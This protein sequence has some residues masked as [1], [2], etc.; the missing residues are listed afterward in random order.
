MLYPITWRVPIHLARFL[1]DVRSSFHFD[2]FMLFLVLSAVVV[3]VAACWYF[4]WYSFC[5]FVSLYSMYGSVVNSLFIYFLFLFQW[6]CGIVIVGLHG[7]RIGW[8]VTAN[9][10][11][12]QENV[13]YWLSSRHTANSTAKWHT[14]KNQQRHKL[15]IPHYTHDIQTKCIQMQKKKKINYNYLC[16]CAAWV[17]FSREF[18]SRHFYAMLRNNLWN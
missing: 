14:Q 16:L 9:Q 2:L 1:F 7:N 10:L 5:A 4:N 6:F 12:C 11:L 3:V 17:F 13:V 15:N 18:G 8:F